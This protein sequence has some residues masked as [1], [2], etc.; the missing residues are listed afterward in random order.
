[1]ELENGGEP[2]PE[3]QRRGYQLA[4]R[5]K[6]GQSGNPK[7]RPKG[8]RNLLGEQFIADVYDVW[9]VR[10]REVLESMCD[11]DPGG[12]ARLVAG[13]LPQKLEA[14]LTLKPSIQGLPLYRQD[15]MTIEHQPLERHEHDLER[16]QDHE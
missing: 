13:I 8:S 4:P 9:Q 15:S 1:M 6:P 12:F 11:N 3:K 2:A 14:E 7:G 10:G 16:L 5:W